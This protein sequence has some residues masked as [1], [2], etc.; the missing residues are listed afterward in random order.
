MTIPRLVLV[1]RATERCDTACA[2]CAFD[3]RL[4]RTRRE[5]EV[6]EAVRFGALVGA[7]ARASGRA[8]MVSW[9]GGEPLLWPGLAAATQALRARE[10][11][12]GMA[13][14]TNGRGLA[15]RRRLRWVTDALDEITV[16]LDG[17]PRLHDELRGRAGLGELVLRAIRELRAERGSG[18]GHAPLVRVNTVLLR[19]NVDAFG[20]LCELVAS[21]GADELTFNA[22]G[23]NDRPEF[24]PANR[25]RG[26]DVERFAAQLPAIRAAAAARGLAVRGSGSYLTR[27]R[28]SAVGTPLGVEDCAP[29]TSFWF[30]E[31]DG[32]VAP[33]SFTAAESA[34][35]V[36]IAELRR[37]EDLDALPARWAA[38]RATSRAASCADCPST[39]VHAKFAGAATGAAT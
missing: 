23:G 9:L 28:A 12:L 11:G 22:L 27:L 8:A 32:R 21:A 18:G 4:R 31:V 3:V 35:G 15:D 34:Y 1:W 24:F 6:D 29:G 36:P 37:G 33:C 10:P 30:V 20:E 26:E 39:H 38:A 19:R 2:F 5:L 17:P 14:T 13:L 7:W 25:L 16:S